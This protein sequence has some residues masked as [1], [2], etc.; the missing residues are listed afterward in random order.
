MN[1]LN[2]PYAGMLFGMIGVFA[3]ILCF[4]IGILLVL[5][6]AIAHWS[7]S[8]NDD[9]EYFISLHAPRF[10]VMGGAIGGLAVLMGWVIQGRVNDE[11]RIANAALA[12]LMSGA[13]VPL[14]TNAGWDSVSS[15]EIAASD[16]AFVLA[17]CG[18][19]ILAGVLLIR[20]AGGVYRLTHGLRTPRIAVLAIGF[21]AGWLAF[22]HFVHYPELSAQQSAHFIDRMRATYLSRLPADRD[23]A[24]VMASAF[25]E[26]PADQTFSQ[27][28][29]RA[30]WLGLVLRQEP[31]KP[32]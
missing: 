7:R 15:M 18:L 24:G 29:R 32:E 17:L 30:Y 3:A 21:L 25:G 6:M 22:S 28:L 4:A 5:S 31:R 14:P 16:M 27:D 23:P 12:R 13:A 20:K 2:N 8:R 19:S 10:L 11:A 26:E 1:F 9:R